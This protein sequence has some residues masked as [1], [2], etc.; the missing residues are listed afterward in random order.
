MAGEPRARAGL[1]AARTG[2]M[3]LRATVIWW[4]GL[5]TCGWVTLT[6]LW[7]LVTGE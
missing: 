2:E 1:S 4:I 5:S 7:T 6:F 3:S